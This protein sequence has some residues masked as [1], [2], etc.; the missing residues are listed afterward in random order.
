MGLRVLT[1]YTC[2]DLCDVYCL[3]E[4]RIRKDYNWPKIGSYLEHCSVG[5]SP[6]SLYLLGLEIIVCKCCLNILL[7][8]KIV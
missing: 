5:D 6:K 3:V 7:K 8:V 2:K 4:R 1:L